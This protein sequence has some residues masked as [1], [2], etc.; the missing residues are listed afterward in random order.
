MFRILFD[1]LRHVFTGNKRHAR[2]PASLFRP[3]GLPRALIH[4]LHPGL[5]E[6]YFRTLGVPTILSSP[7]SRRTLER[8]DL[9]SEPEH[10][11]PVKILDAHLDELVGKVDRVFVP[12]ILSTREGFVSCPKLA[13]LPDA[14]QAQYGDRFQIVTVDLDANREPLERELAALGKRLGYDRAISEAAARQGIL[15]ATDGIGRRMH[16]SG[17]T[18]LRFLAIGHPY[19]LHDE[20][21]TEPVERKL[22][23]L[24]ASLER[25]AFRHGDADGEPLRWDTCADMLAQLRNIDARR[26]AGVIHMTSFNCGCDSMSSIYF[27]DAL[28]NLGV[29]FMALTL[30]AHAGLGGMETRI[31]AFVDSI[32]GAW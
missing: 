25:M 22:S 3:I 9:L 26:I 2:V 15:L 20:F 8:A 19:H 10:C 32:G 4:F 16:S 6:S 31:E 11:L 24:G 18:G 14:V 27:R 13:S 28:K 5:W 7:T 29:P 30:D 17:T 12:R 21:F 23:E 1:H